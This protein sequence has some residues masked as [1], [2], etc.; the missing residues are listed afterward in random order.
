MMYDGSLYINDPDV[1]GYEDVPGLAVQRD[2]GSITVRHY[3]SHDS[4]SC[5]QEQEHVEGMIEFYNAGILDIANDDASGNNKMDL[6]LFLILCA[7][8]FNDTRALA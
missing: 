6:G 7:A 4:N 5:A 8:F 1:N 3:G 2:N